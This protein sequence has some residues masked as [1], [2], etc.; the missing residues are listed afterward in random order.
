MDFVL[1]LFAL[2][3]VV[4]VVLTLRQWRTGRGRM[5]DERIDTPQ[6]EMDRDRM[7]AEDQFFHH[8]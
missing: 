1:G 2:L 6:T 3:L 7:R 4:G 5:I 8:H